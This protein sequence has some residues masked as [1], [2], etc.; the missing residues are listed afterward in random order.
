M[1]GSPLCRCALLLALA[2][3][4]GAAAAEPPQSRPKLDLTARRADE[5]PEALSRRLDEAIAGGN[6]ENALYAYR[7]L[8]YVTGKEDVSRLAAVARLSLVQDMRT[9][10][11]WIRSGAAEVLARRGD[12]EAVELLRRDAAGTEVAP[13][14]RIRAIEVL[15]EIADAASAEALRPI[16]YDDRRLAAERLAAADALLALGDVSGVRYLVSSLGGP[17][18]PER[19]HA[20]AILADRKVAAADALRQASLVEGDDNL[21]IAALRALALQG[22]E[23]AK[24][25]LRK[26]FGDDPSVV[27]PVLVPPAKQSGAAGEELP[28]AEREGEQ[29]DLRLVGRRFTIGNALF[30]V[31]DPTPVSFFENLVRDG[32][33][34][35]DYGRMAG[36]IAG[37]DAARGIALLGEVLAK[38][39]TDSKATAAEELARLGKRDGLVSALAAEYAK[40]LAEDPTASGARLRLV[41][42]L[43]GM[44]LPEAA[45]ALSQALQDAE[46]VVRIAAAKGLADLGDSAGVAELRRFLDGGNRV[47]ALKAAEALM[48]RA[49][50]PLPR[51]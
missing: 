3:L 51:P 17:K 30:D 12:A 38:G 21:R 25:A 27:I 47:D 5:S 40:A 28:Q 9:G 35:G 4:V 18:S 32:R 1:P 48:V 29:L 15:G 7:S 49:P 41:E 23:D 20:A 14:F 16:P 36:R 11:N 22:D 34:P 8:V 31:G 37:F 24:R 33:S 13:P 44:R 26:E 6:F 46:A 42:V 43:A 50:G 2:P 39:D 19:L 10:R 45:P